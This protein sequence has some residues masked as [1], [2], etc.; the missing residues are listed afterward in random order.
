M[1]A[2]LSGGIKC[3]ATQE[4][5]LTETPANMEEGFINSGRVP[6]IALGWRPH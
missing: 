5:I 3:P 1:I 4:V 6:A 2:T